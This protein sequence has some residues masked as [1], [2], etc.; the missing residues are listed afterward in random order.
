[1]TAALREVRRALRRGG[2]IGLTTWAEDPTTPASQI[3]DDELRRCGAWDPSPQ[4]PHHELMN[5]PE[6]VRGL[7]S[8]GGFTP[9]RV[10][11]E[12]VE[13]R[14]DVARFV[15]LR[16]HFGATKRQLDTLDSRTRE[17]FL[18]RIEMLM[19][20]LSSSDLVC[21]GTAIC[22]VAAA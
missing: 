8:V 21:R 17:A 11:I 1:P 4:S 19:S 12:R 22:A 2:A 5:T 13:H 18:G 3:W 15:G 6:K 9:E 20:H 10:W 16:T 14:W 7:L